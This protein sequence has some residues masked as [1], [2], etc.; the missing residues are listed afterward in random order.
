MIM[1]I[2]QPTIYQT[3]DNFEPIDVVHTRLYS[4]DFIGNKREEKKDRKK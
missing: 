3:W 4:L 2:E 1:E